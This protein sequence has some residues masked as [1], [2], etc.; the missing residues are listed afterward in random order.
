MHK[1]GKDLLSA[2]FDDLAEF[3]GMHLHEAGITP[4]SRRPAVSAV[5]GF[6]RWAHKAGIVRKNIAER[7]EYPKISRK[8]PFA[9]ST[10]H[11]ENILMQPDLSTL[12]GCRDAAILGILLGAGL[13]VGGLVALNQEDIYLEEHGGEEI[14]FLR[15]L[16][17]GGHDRVVP[18][19]L[20]SHL[21]VR[22][23]LG[24]PDLA[25]IDRTLPDGKRVLFV[26]FGNRL[27]SPAD[28]Y[29]EK[30]RISRAAV[31]RMIAEYGKRAGVPREVLHPHALRHAYGTELAE[32]GVDIHVRQTLMGHANIASTLLYDRLSVRRMSDAVKS[33]SPF[34]RIRNP[35][36]E[37]ANEFRKRGL[38]GG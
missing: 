27:V 32:A 13:R 37:L 9:M 11:A 35:F 26:T 25:E 31:R 33:A 38:A 19:P 6:Y 23:Y 21:M 3:S 12:K 1:S 22:A 34:K 29:G 17:K 24:H 15:V 7:L 8:L 28:Y 36:S 16:E 20:E 14:I 5:R 18:I 30:R 10:Q 2:T 4:R